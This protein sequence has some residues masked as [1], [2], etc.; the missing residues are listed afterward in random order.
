MK[1]VTQK[2]LNFSENL[3]AKEPKKAC[4]NPK[5]FLTM[6]SSRRVCKMAHRSPISAD[7]L[8]KYYFTLFIRLIEP[9][10]FGYEHQPSDHDFTTSEVNV[11]TTNLKQQDPRPKWRQ[12]SVDLMES[13]YACVVS[14]SHFFIEYWQ[15]WK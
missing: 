9:A 8:A 6:G 12:N 4:E 15:R 10:N 5:D 1:Y 14:F 11:P 7:K 3:T 13:I 2:I